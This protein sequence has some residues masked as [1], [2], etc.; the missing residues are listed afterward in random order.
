MPTGCGRGVSRVDRARGRARGPGD[1]GGNVMPKPKLSEK[2]K[3]E[4]PDPKA[5]DQF[6]D[7]AR[8][9]V[10]V[11]KADVENTDQEDSRS[12][13]ETASGS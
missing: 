3:N 8:R 6:A 2:I 7:F 4:P 11:S 9:I 10:Q 12:T 1:T 5:F 13:T